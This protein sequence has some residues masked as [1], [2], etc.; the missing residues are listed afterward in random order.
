MSRCLLSLFAGSLLLLAGCAANNRTVPAEPPRIE[1][2]SA[3]ELA[4]ITPQP[5]AKLSLDDIVRLTMQGSTPEQ[6]IEKIR[7]TDSL[8]DLTPSQSVDL[9]RQGVDAKVLDHLHASHEAALRN[10]M[11]DEINRR[12]KE[13]QAELARVKDKLRQQ[14]YYDP[15][16]GYGPYGMMPYGYGGFGSRYGSRFGLGAGFGRPLG[17]W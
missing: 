3:E 14:R 9:S 15:Y 2:I 1:R 8:F 10:S 12:E 4:R 16:C 17:C 6:I 11:A 5:V 7:V 13:K